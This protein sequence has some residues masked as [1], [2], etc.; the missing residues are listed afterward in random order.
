MYTVQIRTL[1]N[2]TTAA[3]IISRP[4]WRSL[5]TSR[6]P[7]TNRISAAMTPS[8]RAADAIVSIPIPFT[9]L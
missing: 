7:P 5:A 2:I 6:T 9:K 8:A 3:A 4:R 1:P